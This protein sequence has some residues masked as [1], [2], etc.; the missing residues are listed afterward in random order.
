MKQH[1]ELKASA[2]M[3]SFTV[4]LSMRTLASHS[5]SS[6]HFPQ[7]LPVTPE[8]FEFNDFWVL[9]QYA[10]QAARLGVAMYFAHFKAFRK[11]WA[12]ISLQ[13]CTHQ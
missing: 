3:F 8:G 2:K 6:R 9:I 13:C 12:A 10:D 11:T 4:L 5:S 7:L 1:W